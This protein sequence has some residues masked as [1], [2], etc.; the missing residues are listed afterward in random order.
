[1]E[2]SIL[3]EELLGLPIDSFHVFLWPACYIDRVNDD[4]QDIRVDDMVIVLPTEF[5]L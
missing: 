1:M 4:W 5:V 3:W 2:T